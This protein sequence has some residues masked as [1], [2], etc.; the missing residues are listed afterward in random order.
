MDNLIAYCG[1]NCAQCE[2]YMATQENDLQKREAVAKKWAAEYDAPGLTAR[3]IVCNGCASLEGPWFSHCSECSFRNCAQSKGVASCAVCE[4]YPCSDLAGFLNAV[5][6]AKD[7][8][9]AI[10]KA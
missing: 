9:E 2:A 8:L 4:E 6:M 1:L 3:D 5:P 10:R 7:N